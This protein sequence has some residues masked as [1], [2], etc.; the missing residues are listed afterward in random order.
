MKVT[1]PLLIRLEK[2]VTPLLLFNQKRKKKEI[3]NIGGLSQ[4][5]RYTNT[6]FGEYFTKKIQWDKTLVKKINN[7]NIK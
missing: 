2:N 4:N 5:S 1:M 3:M 6:C 7:V